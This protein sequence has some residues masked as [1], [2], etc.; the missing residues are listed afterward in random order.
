MN[1]KDNDPDFEAYR[2]ER[3]YRRR[4]RTKTERPHG[5]ANKVWEELNAHE[6]GEIHDR[7]LTREVHDFFADATKMAADIVS[8]VA[9]EH[10]E[11]VSERLRSEMEEF[12]RETIRRASEF[13]DVLGDGGERGEEILE[14]DMKNLVGR[15]LDEFRAEGTAN[16][17]DK[18]LGQDPFMTDVKLTKSTRATDADERDDDLGIPTQRIDPAELGLSPSIPITDEKAEELSGELS[19]G[20]DAKA[21]GHLADADDE[22][23]ADPPMTEAE[24]AKLRE[25]LKTM[26]RQGLMSKDEARETY[27]VRI[28]KQE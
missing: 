12:L 27:R 7:L 9:E 11:Q 16:V 8:K 14:A 24:R 3:N 25:A 20:F 28:G 19:G 17:E 4:Q 15:V 2:E 22:K 26:V 18:H 5:P 21:E 23:P 13:I 6:E 1:Q 10:E